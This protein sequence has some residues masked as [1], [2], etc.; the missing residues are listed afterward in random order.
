MLQPHLLKRLPSSNELLLHLVQIR[1]WDSRGSTSGFSILFHWPC[2]CPFTNTTLS[3]LQQSYS[4]VCYQVLWFCPFYYSFSRWFLWFLVPLPFQ[5]NFRIILPYLQ[6]NTLLGFLLAST[7]NPYISLE[8]TN[9]SIM[10]SLSVHEHGMCL[11]LF[12]FALIYQYFA[13]FSI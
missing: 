3:W 8:G 13:V 7:S 10:L 11:H 9:L 1:W 4:E 6:K 5:I 12:G 2:V